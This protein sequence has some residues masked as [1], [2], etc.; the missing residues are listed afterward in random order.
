MGPARL[1]DPGA[2]PRTPK[3]SMTEP[4]ACGGNVYPK[5]I[6]RNHLYT[7]RFRGKSAKDASARVGLR[8]LIVRNPVRRHIAFGHLRDKPRHACIRDPQARG[9]AFCRIRKGSADLEPVLVVALL[10]ERDS[11]SAGPRSACGGPNQSAAGG[12]KLRP[13]QG[14][15]SSHRDPRIVHLCGTAICPFL[16]R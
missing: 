13:Q 3:D 12:P 14:P 5:K 10:G 1:G 9:R 16:G 6:A 11:M 2:W 7:L 15:R 4:L 8:Q